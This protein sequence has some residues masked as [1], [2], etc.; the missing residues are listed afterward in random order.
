MSTSNQG[1][2]NNTTTTSMGIRLSKTRQQQEHE[3][4]LTCTPDDWPWVWALRDWSV[5]D[6]QRGNDIPSLT[7]TT[8]ERDEAIQEQLASQ[9]NLPVR[10][11]DTL[12]LGNATC[13]QNIPLLQA[14]GITSVLNM[15]GVFAVPAK[16]I[17]LY[18]QKGIAYKQIEA[19]DDMEYPLLQKHWLEAKEF[20]DAN[21]AATTSSSGNNNHKD[22][23]KAAAQ[24]KKCV[25]N[26]LAGINRSSLIVAT[27]YMLQT[28]TS[29]LDTV[30]HLRK[31][32]GNIALHNEGF[33]EQ[34]VAMARQH[35]LLGPAPGTPGSI[36]SQT[37]PPIFA[38]GD[39]G[40]DDDW[41]V[42]R[43]ENANNGSAERR[44]KKE[45]NPLVDRRS[46]I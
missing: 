25:V 9:R 19:E 28:R 46:K 24:T 39:S 30:R 20:I 27:Y 17:E 6:W 22:G 32:R 35:D 33:Q 40:D 18:K 4:S 14:L 23:T 16:T 3:H 12:Y 37:P 44:A 36:V 29:V 41:R 8:K 7:A 42:F 10:I 43:P 5:L 26:C 2:P 15:A 11:T 38:Q 13:V 45:R 34:L 1:D 31:Q 21:T